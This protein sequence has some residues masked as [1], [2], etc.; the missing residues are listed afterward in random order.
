MGKSVQNVVHAKFKYLS[1]YVLIVFLGVASC[2]GMLLF[3]NYKEQSK[4]LSVAQSFGQTLSLQQIQMLTGT[5][6]DLDTE[7]YQ[8]LKNQLIA[9]KASQQ[10]MRFAYLMGKDRQGNIMFLV[11]A[12]PEYSSEY[13]PPG[14][15]YSE[16]SKALVQVF[17][18]KESIVEGPEKDS[19]GTW[20]SALV[21][22]VDPETGKTLALLG[23]DIN[24]EN[25]R[26]QVFA[27]SIIPITFTVILLILI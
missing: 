12:E 10:N 26:W 13:S 17:T 21:P 16:A 23:F 20:V 8:T 2:V 25:W 15:V 6:D 27:N 24:A 14:Q 22:I 18:T 1:M 19:W 11:D 4:L 5:E 3:S 9:I 7:G